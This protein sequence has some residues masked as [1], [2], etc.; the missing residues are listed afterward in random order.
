MISDNPP[1]NCNYG[2]SVTDNIK[3]FLACEYKVHG[4]F[5]EGM[6]SMVTLW[7]N[8]ATDHLYEIKA[9]K[10]KEW[11]K[12]RKLVK[13]LQNDGLEMGHSFNGK[14]YTLKDI[15]ALWELV[16]KI[17]LLIDEK[18]GLSPDWGEW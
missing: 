13:V 16:K 3:Y 15:L 8:G 9:P 7:A 2:K 4:S 5:K 6:S 18:L 12:I 14:E 11:N 1:P 17:C 10:G